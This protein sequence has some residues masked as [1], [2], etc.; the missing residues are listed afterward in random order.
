M[1]AWAV[2]LRIRLSSRFAPVFQQAAQTG[3]TIQHTSR[4]LHEAG[5]EKQADGYRVY[6]HYGRKIQLASID[7]I[8]ASCFKFRAIF[9]ALHPIYLVPYS[10]RTNVE[11]IT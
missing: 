11:V 4:R 1:K 10:K 6:F 9:S 7:V 2:M 8:Q 5:C 3:V